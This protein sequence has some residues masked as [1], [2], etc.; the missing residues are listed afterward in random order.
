ML[1]CGLQAFHS[2]LSNTLKWGYDIFLLSLSFIVWKLLI[3][4]VLLIPYVCCESNGPLLH[5][6]QLIRMVETGLSSIVSF[7]TLVNFLRRK[8]L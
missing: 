1:E 7:E 4:N 2:L 5:T 3:D 8:A 6:F